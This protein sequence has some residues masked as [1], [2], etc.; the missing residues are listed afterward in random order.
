MGGHGSSGDIVLE[1]SVPRFIRNNCTLKII[2]NGKE[3]LQSW[4]FSGVATQRW[5]GWRSFMRQPFIPKYTTETWTFRIILLCRLCLTLIM[6]GQ[7][8]RKFPVSLEVMMHGHGQVRIH[9]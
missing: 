6:T 5:D 4:G 1:K 7:M 3:H 8:K 2:P 9:V